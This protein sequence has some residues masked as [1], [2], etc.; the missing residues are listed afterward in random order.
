MQPDAVLPA[1]IPRQE[2]P[3]DA[4]SGGDGGSAD[5][6]T[7]ADNGLRPESSPGPSDNGN[8]N[9]GTPGQADVAEPAGG[10]TFPTPSKVDA[11]GGGV[12]RTPYS[13]PAA[14]D[15][16]VA[17]EAVSTLPGPG[18]TL[19]QDGEAT[20]ATSTAYLVPAA[21]D[22]ISTLPDATLTRSVAA[23]NDPAPTLPPSRGGPTAIQGGSPAGDI[24]KDGGQISAGQGGPENTPAALSLPGQPPAPSGSQANRLVGATAT[25]PHG[26]TTVSL[27]PGQPTPSPTTGPSG[28]DP[29]QQLPYYLPMAV[30]MQAW[31]LLQEVL[32]GMAPSAQ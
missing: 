32:R 1:V 7:S 26:A 15:I 25:P 13:V 2:P 22:A 21:T 29:A 23:A 24:G 3:V 8:D 14:T 6:G 19:P 28:L 12:S 27:L 4:G 16:R 9:Q 18:R 11:G 10:E 30:A 20:R 17:T 5:N 31:Q